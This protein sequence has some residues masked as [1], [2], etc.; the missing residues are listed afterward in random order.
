MPCCFWIC[1]AL[2]LLARSLCLCLCLCLCASLC[3]CLC[4]CL[5]A[6]QS[7]SLSA[8]LPV[9][10]SS[11]FCLLSSPPSPSLTSDTQRNQPAATPS[12]HAPKLS[13]RALMSV[14]GGRLLNRVKEV[15]WGRQVGASMQRLA[16]LHVRT[17]TSSPFSAQEQSS[18]STCDLPC[19]DRYTWLDIAQ[20]DFIDLRARAR[21]AAI[22]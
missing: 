7:V 3:L 15:V 18:D 13:G 8:H 2:T 16:C 19:Q 12:A 21:V 10:R 14:V 5:C 17:E 4:L 20:A 1:F 6:C 22:V 11:V 9:F